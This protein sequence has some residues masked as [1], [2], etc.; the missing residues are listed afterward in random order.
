[1]TRLGQALK[2]APTALFLDFDGTLVGIAATPSVVRVP[3]DLGRLLERASAALGGALAIISGRPIAAIDAMTAPLR[4]P[5]A[6]VHGA[7]LRMEPGSPIVAAAPRIAPEL[8]QA[9]RAAVGDRKG[10]LVE[11]KTYSVAVH[12]RLAPD[13]RP[14]IE[15]ALR[16]LL[17][18]S[19][20]DV[21]L[22]RGRKIVE[23]TPRMATKGGALLAF[24][25]EPPFAGRRPIMVGDDL[26]DESA[27]AAARG[28]GGGGLKVAG[29]HFPAE[30]ADFADPTAV[31]AW[32]KSLTEGGSLWHDRL[33]T[34]P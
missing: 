31:R 25:R 21:V 29:E 1:V 16:E 34:L 15:A 22:K 10:L 24:M 9:V 5:A 12:Y 17:H 3:S 8:V 23:V 33:S 28:L 6:G 14:R 32:L 27:M 18:E 19:A 26:T 4:L 7:E 2:D 30:D 13:E 20:D 11:E